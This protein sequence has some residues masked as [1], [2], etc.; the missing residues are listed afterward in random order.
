MNYIQAGEHA[1]RYSSSYT[2]G[3]SAYRELES[4]GE[5]KKMPL[6]P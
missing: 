4:T 6:K 1:K 2:K 3:Q 5:H